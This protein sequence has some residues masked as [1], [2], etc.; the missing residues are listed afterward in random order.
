MKISIKSFEELTKKE[1]YEILK[2]R[3]EIFVVEQ[4]CFYLDPDD[5]DYQSLHLVIEKN[6]EI[7]SYLRII[8]KGLSYDTA[9]IGRVLTSPKYRGK[10]LSRMA[11][12]DAI[13]YIKK[14]WQEPKITIG[15]QYYLEK[16]YTSL[17]FIRVSDIYLDAGIEHID[18][19]LELKNE[20]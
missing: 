12:Q 15:A 9:S 4:H 6:D 19:I 14:E 11:M 7:A 2:L 17:G 13:D 20:A 5:K 8:P 16:F 1:L 18:M 10:G 3:A